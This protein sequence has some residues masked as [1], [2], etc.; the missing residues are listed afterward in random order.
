MTVYA[1]SHELEH[2][3]S[4]FLGSCW[5]H[6]ILYSEKYIFEVRKGVSSAENRKLFNQLGSDSHALG[7]FQ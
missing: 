5:L 7:G 3:M 4:A 1:S 6:D 2:D